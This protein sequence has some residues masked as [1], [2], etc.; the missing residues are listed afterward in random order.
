M[1]PFEYVVVLISIILGLGI[2]TILTGVAEW[3]KQ[4]RPGA[5]YL[6]Y[7]IWIV[8]VFVMHVHEW[9]TSYALRSVEVWH[10]P[11]FLFLILYPIGLYV[12]AHLLFPKHGDAPFDPRAYYQQN[13]RKFFVCTMALAFIS[14]THNVAVAGLPLTSQ[15][16]HAV[17]VISL[18]AVLAS[19][20]QRR[21]V[22][23]ALALM[24][25]AVLLAA[26][27]FTTQQLVIGA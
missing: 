3:I 2:T 20:T 27:A 22:H 5:F 4:F 14:F 10:L 15:V 26:L 25:L 19:G 21:S 11:L 6:P 8:L 23:L 24:L 9:W 18:G 7:A 12:L 13:H 1:S 16:P 17:I